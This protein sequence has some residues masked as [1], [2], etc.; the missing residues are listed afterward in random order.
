MKKVLLIL[1]LLI[2]F[3]GIVSAQDSSKEEQKEVYKKMFLE[4]CVSVKQRL[5][6]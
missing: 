2:Q 4:G 6:N 5:K 1:I 3:V